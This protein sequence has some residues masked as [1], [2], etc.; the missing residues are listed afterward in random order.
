VCTANIWRARNLGAN[1]E[2]RAH[3]SAQVLTYSAFSRPPIVNL[4]DMRCVATMSDIS[5]LRLERIRSVS[6]A[7]M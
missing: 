2:S 6:I 5:R 4:V 1:R 3:V 7:H